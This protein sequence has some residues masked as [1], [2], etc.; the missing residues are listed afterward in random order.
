MHTACIDG[1][2]VLK[3]S[4][5][6]CPWNASANWE[7]QQLEIC[8]LGVAASRFHGIPEGCSHRDQVEQILRSLVYSPEDDRPYPA[9]TDANNS[10]G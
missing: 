3:C 4:D 2:V 8:N 1:K 10:S 9:R 7:G 6:G 5:S